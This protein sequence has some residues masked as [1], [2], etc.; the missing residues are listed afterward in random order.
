MPDELLP[1]PRMCLILAH[2]LVATVV[3]ILASFFIRFEETGSPNGG[4]G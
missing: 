2:D 1:T 4:T 3:A